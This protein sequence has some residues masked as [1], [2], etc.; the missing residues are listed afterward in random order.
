MQNNQIIEYE[1]KL[2]KAMLASDVKMLDELIHDNLIF[3]N[4]FG[5]MLNKEADLE[6]HRS[7]VLHFTDIQ[8]MDQKV[9]P[10]DGTAVT[11]TRVS[12]QGTVGS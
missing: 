6:A 1:E 7:G 4:H 3:V 9:I 10:L 11:I 5:Q 12:L 2:R 8:V